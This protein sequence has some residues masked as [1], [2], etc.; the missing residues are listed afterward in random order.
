M[1]TILR[2]HEY[3]EIAETDHG[4]K[5]IRCLRCGH[6]FCKASEN[7]KEHALLWERS[8]EDIPCRTPV[9]GE[10]MFIRYQE[11]IC[12]GCATLLE[13]DTVCPELDKEQPIIW[14]IQVE[15]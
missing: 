3:L 11:F 8:L 15:A 10:A 12:P 7:Y 6:V 14:D 13:V 2:I 5:V 9:S 4:Q 1:K